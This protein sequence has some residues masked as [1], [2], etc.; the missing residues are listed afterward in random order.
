MDDI[1]NYQGGYAASSPAAYDTSGQMSAWDAWALARVGNAIDAGVDRVIN[2]PQ[3]V[4]DAGIAYGIN[5]AG[6][7]YQLGRPGTAGNA[8]VG[9]NNTLL[10]LGVL[11][12]LAFA[13]K[14]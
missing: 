6:Q 13:H 8:G 10:V 3:I 2:Q 14:G 5:G 4:T 7:L 12:L 9:V 1:T 11:F